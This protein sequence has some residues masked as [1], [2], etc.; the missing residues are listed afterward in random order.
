MLFRSPISFR[1]VAQIFLLFS[2]SSSPSA[3]L[4]LSLSFAFS[5]DRVVDE[6]GA[7]WPNIP[8]SCLLNSYPPPSHR[9]CTVNIIT[10]IVSDRTNSSIDAR[11][12][13]PRSVEIRWFSLCSIR[14]DSETP[15]VKCHFFRLMMPTPTAFM[16]PFLVSVS[17]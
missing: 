3:A 15:F 10:T 7:C 1:C 17:R 4:P 12:F 13:R 2:F 11:L 8:Q 16:C 6:N 14:A 9:H 5:H